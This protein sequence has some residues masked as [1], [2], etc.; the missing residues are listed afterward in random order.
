MKISQSKNIM[1]LLFFWGAGLLLSILCLVPPVEICLSKKL[2]FASFSFHTGQTFCENDIFF[3]GFSFSDGSNGCP[4][5][6]NYNF[7]SFVVF[8]SV[9]C[10][11]VGKNSQELTKVKG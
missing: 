3:I 7:N 8:G 11:T 5:F 6:F 4:F 1:R 9:K 10:R 2:I